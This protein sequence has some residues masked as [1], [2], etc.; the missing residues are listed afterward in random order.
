MIIRKTE[1]RYVTNPP[2]FLVRRDW[3]LFFILF[4]A[5]TGHPDKK[6]KNGFPFSLGTVWLRFY[7]Y[8]NRANE[9]VYL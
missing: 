8:Q 2:P 3:G 6:K 9:G 1:Q 4:S 7:S 5:F